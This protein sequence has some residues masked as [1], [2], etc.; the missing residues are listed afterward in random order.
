MA[1]RMAGG[2][3]KLRA[4]EVPAMNCPKCDEEMEH[5]DYD[6]DV[7]IMSAYFFCDACDETVDDDGPDPECDRSDFD[8]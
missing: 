3:T 4:Q 7:G 6:P 8:P 1:T 5:V 2:K